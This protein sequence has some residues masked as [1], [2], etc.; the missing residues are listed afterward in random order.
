[1]LS[2][3]VP[4]V[5]VGA[6]RSAR[7]ALG[8]SGEHLTVRRNGSTVLEQVSL[9][10]AS[11]QILRVA[12]SNGA[13]KSSLLLAL[14]G[15]LPV[16]GGFV[17]FGGSAVPRSVADWARIG[18]ART[19]QAPQPFPEWTVRENV[20]IAAERAGAAGE[21]DSILEDLHL[22]TLRDRRADQ[23]SVGEGKRLELARALALRPAILLLDEPL[24]GLSPDS[25]HRVAALIARIRDA[26]TPVV[27]VEHQF[28]PGEMAD[29]LLI[30]ED[31]RVTFYGHPADWEAVRLGTPA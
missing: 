14:A 12:G 6:A 24:A 18:V 19:F 11:G 8:L 2:A 26:G 29:R 21:V 31:G 16:H 3:R 30:L 28:A 20:A 17:R 13:G 25:A 1:L 15:A 9:N 5:P 22:A 23:L 27:W 7:R 4:L 10:V